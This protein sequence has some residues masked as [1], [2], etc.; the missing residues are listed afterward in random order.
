MPTLNNLRHIS[1]TS[2]FQSQ[3]LVFEIEDESQHHQLPFEKIQE[4]VKMSVV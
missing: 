1:Y 4:V 3:E 2:L